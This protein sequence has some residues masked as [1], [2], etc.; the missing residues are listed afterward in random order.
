VQPLLRQITPAQF[1]ERAWKTH[2]TPEEILSWIIRGLDGWSGL[3][4]GSR[5][6]FGETSRPSFLGLAKPEA[7]IR[8]SVNARGRSL[9]RFRGRGRHGGGWE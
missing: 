2:R 6:V 8:I 4:L 5:P 3:R 9:Q 7:D 1:A